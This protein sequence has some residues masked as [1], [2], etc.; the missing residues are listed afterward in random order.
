MR[1]REFTTI[2]AGTAVAWPLAARAQQSAMPVVGFLGTASADEYAH[3]MPGFH[4]GLSETGYVEGQNVV[5]ESRFAENHVDRLPALVSELIDRHVAAIFATGGAAPLFAATAA[6]VTTPI[7]FAN[8][9]DPVKFVERGLIGSLNRPG[10]NITGASFLSNAL[11][12]K[13]L[14]LLHELVPQ[15]S[16]VAVLIDP[17]D[18]NAETQTRQLQETARRLG[19]QLQFSAVGVND[20]F[21]AVF[22]TISRQRAG[23]LFV[24]T[25]GLFTSRRDQLVALAARFGLPA[26]YSFREFTA[27]G[28]LMSY[29]SSL[30]DGFRQAG[31]Y[32]GLILK[33]TK[34][35]DLP[36]MQ[37]TKFELAIYH[38]TAKV[39]GLEI[40]PTLLALADEVIE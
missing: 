19:I 38:K 7:V 36:V 13:R 22:A 27:G 12:G 20:D 25:S 1:R 2:L 14:A 26:S 9:S 11:E 37:P 30:T 15:A 18:P 31:V 5:L 4:R 17:D 28:G 6:T 39:L 33:G 23:A 32:T 3:F 40:P 10:G 24:A 8:G 35:G 34:P 29:G 21:D 16:L